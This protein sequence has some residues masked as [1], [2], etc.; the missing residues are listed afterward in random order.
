MYLCG[1]FTKLLVII[2]AK[3]LSILLISPLVGYLKVDR[4]QHLSL[5]PF[6]QNVEPI[7][8]LVLFYQSIICMRLRLMEFNVFYFKL[9][10]TLWGPIVKVRERK[11]KINSMESISWC[12]SSLQLSTGR[13][14]MQRK[15]FACHS[16]ISLSNKN[17]LSFEQGRGIL[18]IQTFTLSYSHIMG[19]F[20]SGEI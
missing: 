5:F 4:I 3:Q 11:Q 2:L 15:A 8:R 6:H 17:L 19:S 16:R 9:N 13:N 7:F 20:L 14:T 10:D 1:T 18:T 12:F